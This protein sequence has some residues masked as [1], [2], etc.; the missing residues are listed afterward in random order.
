[1]CVQWVRGG[2][3]AAG[4]VWLGRQ[5]GNVRESEREGNGRLFPRSVGILF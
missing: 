5:V 4:F 2:G 1:M 3:Y